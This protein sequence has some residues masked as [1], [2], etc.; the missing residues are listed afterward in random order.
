MHVGARGELV[1]V[2]A[3]RVYERDGERAH[4]F[5]RKLVSAV[6]NG[7][8]TAVEPH[9]SPAVLAVQ[10]DVAHT[11]LFEESTERSHRAARL[12]AELVEKLISHAAI[13]DEQSRETGRR[14]LTVSNSKVCTLVPQR[15]I[16][17]YRK[18]YIKPFLWRLS[19]SASL[20]KAAETVVAG[21]SLPRAA[22]QR[23]G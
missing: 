21:G 6:A 23:I 22:T 15:N 19:S 2:A 16:F 12:K 9:L 20:C 3:T 17:Y 7:A 8:V 11:P 18:K 10:E 5:I 14:A 13:R 4:L 1:N